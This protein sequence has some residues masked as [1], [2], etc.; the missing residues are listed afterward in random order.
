MIWGPCPRLEGM[1]NNYTF[2]NWQVYSLATLNLLIGIW[3]W[4][5]AAFVIISPLTTTKRNHI[6]VYR[7]VERK[8]ESAVFCDV[9]GRASSYHCERAG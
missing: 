8:K 6:G 3:L 2:G 1:L 5:D 7:G 4:K 9:Y